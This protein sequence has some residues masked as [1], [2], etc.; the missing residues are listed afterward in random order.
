MGLHMGTD[1]RRP[2]LRDIA[3]RVGVSEAAASFAL[4]GKPGVS[5]ATRQR[6][7]QA[8]KALNWAPHHAARALTGAGTATVGLVIARSAQDVGSELFFH[9]LMTGMQAVLSRRQYALLLQV[10]DSVDE[11]I[12]VYHTWKREN[13]VD[14]VVLVDLRRN[15]PR[16]EAVAELELPALIA[17]GPDPAGVVPS[18]SI[19]DAAAMASIMRHLKETGHERVAYLSGSITLLH[20]HRRIESFL[21]ASADLGIADCRSHATDF[22]AGA[23]DSATASALLGNPRPTALIYDNEVL[24]VAGVGAI[25]RMSLRIPEDVAVVVWEDTPVCTVLQPAL[26]ALRRD[27]AGFGADVAEHLLKVLAG[28]RVADFEERVPTLVARAS[29]IGETPAGAS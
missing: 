9:R 1:A 2:T 28:E 15:D 17:G 24:A 4:N 10:V 22:S 21:R 29:T 7:L 13:R 18:V 19:D 11:E 6:V 14:G 16:P 5:E 25:R 8:A 3:E 26:T 20:V 12:A 23:G 27:A